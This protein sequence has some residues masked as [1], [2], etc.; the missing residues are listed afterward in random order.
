MALSPPIRKALL[1]VH[2]AVSVGWIG[3]V[4]AYLSLG[5]A[6]SR[7]T[8]PQTVRGAWIAME[9]MGWYVLVPLAISSVVT[10]VL[11]SLGSRWGLFRHYWVVVSFLLTVVAAV[12]LVLHLPSVSSTAARARGA[13]DEILF[14]LGGDLFHAALALVLLLAV[15]ALNVYKPQGVTPYGWRKQRETHRAT[16]Q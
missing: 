7:S 13:S 2:L 9:I 5:V 1:A 6:A 15:Q 10:G 12:V 14:T 11:L 8:D 3:A 16:A 4:L